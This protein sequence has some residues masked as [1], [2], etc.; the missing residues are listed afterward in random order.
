MDHQS[1]PGLQD[2]SPNLEA[3]IRHLP[4][5]ERLPHDQKDVPVCEISRMEYGFPQVLNNYH[6][7][8]I[9]Y[10]LGRSANNSELYVSLQAMHKEGGLMAV[11][12]LTTQSTLCLVKYT[13]LQKF[14]AAASK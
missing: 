11:G 10:V 7:E 2:D 6:H 8:Y 1:A 14:F 9:A 12:S 13:P 5:F 4:V 3:L